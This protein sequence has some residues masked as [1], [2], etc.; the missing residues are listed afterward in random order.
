MDSDVTVYEY[1]GSGVHVEVGVYVTPGILWIGSTNY[2]LVSDHLGRYLTRFNR[3]VS[4]TSVNS[5]GKIRRM[6]QPRDRE[7]AGL[8][9]RFELTSI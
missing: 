1:G 4:I 7:S 9:K 2:C 3:K 6:L 8:A 5:I